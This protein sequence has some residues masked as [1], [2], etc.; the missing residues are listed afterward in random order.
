M[1]LLFCIFTWQDLRRFFSK[2]RFLRFFL[3][4]FRRIFWDCF[5]QNWSPFVIT[6]KLCNFSIFF[7]I[8]EIVQKFRVVF[9]LLVRFSQIFS[10]MSWSWNFSAWVKSF[11]IFSNKTFFTYLHFS[12]RERIRKKFIYIINY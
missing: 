5:S 1:R 3:N 10:T 9:Y 8:F 4:F 6:I 11:I 12:H 7:K 2:F